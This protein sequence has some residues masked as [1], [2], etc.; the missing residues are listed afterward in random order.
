[1]GNGCDEL[2]E[3]ADFVADENVKDGIYKT[4]E[5]FGWFE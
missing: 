2:K 1:M 4:C 3:K 5:K